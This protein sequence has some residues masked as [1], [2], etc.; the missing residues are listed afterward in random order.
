[1]SYRQIKVSVRYTGGKTIKTSPV[2]TDSYAAA[3]TARTI[4]D[5]NT[6]LWKETAYILCLNGSNVLLGWNCVSIGCADSVPLDIRIIATIALKTIAAGII[7]THNHPCGN[8]LPSSQ[9]IQITRRLKS[10]HDIIGIK[11]LDHII[12]TDHDQFSMKDAFLF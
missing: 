3:Y 9:D 10:A 6:I 2:I 11:L 1:M 4:H 7:I 12:L 5:K 8:I